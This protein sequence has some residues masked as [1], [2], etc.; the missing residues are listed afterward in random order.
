MFPISFARNDR[1]S[2]ARARQF[3][4]DGHPMREHYMQS[5]LVQLD[6]KYFLRRLTRAD[7]EDR[8][9]MLEDLIDRSF[10]FCWLLN[11]IRLEND[12]TTCFSIYS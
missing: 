4:F 7:G 9:F 8:Y 6:A 3:T 10:D 12:G 1:V 2:V 5:V 11:L